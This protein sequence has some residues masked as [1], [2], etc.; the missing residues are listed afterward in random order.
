MRYPSIRGVRTGGRTVFLRA[1]LNVPVENGRVMDDGRITAS[2]PTL[3][4]LLDQGSPVV[5][6]SHLGRPKGAPEPRYSMAPVAGRLSELL[7]EYEVLFIDRVSGRRV[8]AMARGLFPG[9]VLLIENLRFHPG[10]EQND[11]EFSR[12]LAG[13]A[14]LYVNDA[15]GTCHREHASTAGVPEAMG[16]G[17]AGLLVEKELEAF[18]R[19]VT[20][21][22]KPFTVL[23]G[24]AK[25]SDKVA[26]IQ[27]VLP[28]LDDLLIGGAMAF[29]FCRARGVATGKSLVEEDRVGTAGEIMEA[30][31][32]SGVN[33]VLPVDFVCARS[34]REEPVTTPWDRIPED[35]AGYDIGPESVRLFR[36]VIMKSGTVV[37]N[38]PMGLFEVPPFDAATR[39][40]AGML[41]EATVAGAVTI[42]GGGDSLR[43]VTEA[44]ALEK[45]THAST[46]GGASLELLQGNELP[47]L[48]HIAKEGARPL[49]GANWKMNGTLQEAR[50]Y[51]DDLMVSNCSHFDCD[52]VL[53]P[54]FTLLSGLAGYAESAGVA[55]GGQDVFW[56]RKGAFTG[57]ISPAMLLD[58]GCSW[59]LAGH[60]ERR[61]VL[62]E[63]D[64]VV[65]G[66]LQAGIGAGL[67]G[68]LCVGETLD[69][70][71]A[72]RTGEVV[73]SQLERSLRG[74]KGAD[75][76]NLA[77]AYEPVWAIGTGVNATPVQ[78]QEVHELIRAWIA[79]AFGSAFAAETRV[80]YG[81][82][83][84]PAN[85]GE[86][87]A[88]PD[89]NGALVGGAS[90]DSGSFLDILASL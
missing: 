77:V 62:G 35:M 71:K 5:L 85:A 68:I 76:A 11:R 40:V 75:P 17:F 2:L 90:L 81:G 82:S 22:R 73:T 42:V 41:A 45:V 89:V 15:F 37:W 49:F 34:P 12:A 14:E 67:K 80:I 43:A 56:E 58:A 13:L 61:H 84:T 59:F 66:K 79:D 51:L 54:P 31:R 16:G 52:T 26:M 36:E 63:S 44:G 21:P 20:H 70:R 4:Y 6:A 39:E 3:K 57:E 60:S 10:E 53:F 72:G 28:R 30:A 8:E 87:L 29:T 88:Q 78:A 38:G 25:V 50:D 74:L 33:L 86:I 55:L 69:E 1:D 27:H 65:A 18:G 48:R 23:M 64:E 46:G 19:M 24:G 83:V 32:R 9:Q 7:E 47:A